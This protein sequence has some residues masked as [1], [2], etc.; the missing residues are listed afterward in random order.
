MGVEGTNR[1][2]AEVAEGIA[3]MGGGE[4]VASEKG[5]AWGGLGH[6]GG[7]GPRRRTERGGTNAV[8]RP[9]ETDCVIAAVCRSPI[10]S[11]DYG[12]STGNMKRLK[13]VVPVIVIVVLGL[14]VAWCGGRGT[15][16]GSAGPEPAAKR[17]RLPKTPREFPSL[18]RKSTSRDEMAWKSSRSGEELKVRK[19]LKM[20][21]VPV[22]EESGDKATA[23]IEIRV[24]EAAEVRDGGEWVAMP[25]DLFREWTKDDPSDTHLATATMIK[26]LEDGRPVIASQTATG[27]GAEKP[28]TDYNETESNINITLK[29]KGDTLTVLWTSAGFEQASEEIEIPFGGRFLGPREDEPPAETGR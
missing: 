25:E 3:E 20:T 15:G 4:G 9:A 7:V 6:A 23:R 1:G 17:A 18:D 28:V 10:A 27:S 13:V 5:E 19:S 2:G 16:E 14:A 21:A 11:P 12:S 24:S 29:W 26:K 22:I 8:R